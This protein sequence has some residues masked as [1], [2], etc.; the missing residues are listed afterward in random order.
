MRHPW[1]IARRIAVV[2]V[3]LVAAI[4]LFS[5][6][7]AYLQAREVAQRVE[8]RHVQGVTTL[9]ARDPALVSALRAGDAPALQAGICLL[10]TSPS[11]RDKRQSRMPSSA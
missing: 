10:Y 5:V 11:P 7:S 4:A 3:A 6:W 2:H 8:E 1:S 9:V